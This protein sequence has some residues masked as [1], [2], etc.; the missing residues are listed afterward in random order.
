VNSFFI[1]NH[2]QNAMILTSLNISVNLNH[3]F[4]IF[5]LLLID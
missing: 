4:Y 2:C 5:W 1:K 3:T